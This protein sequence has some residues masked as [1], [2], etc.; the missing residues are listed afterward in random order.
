MQMNGFDPG[1]Y[2]G[3]EE[4]LWDKK[5]IKQPLSPPY[6]RSSLGTVPNIC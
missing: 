3:G 6:V 5:E 2:D 1:L 4:T